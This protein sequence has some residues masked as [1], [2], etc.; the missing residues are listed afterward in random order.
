MSDRRGA[1]QAMPRSKKQ[2]APTSFGIR[3][4]EKWICYQADDSLKL[5]TPR[6]WSTIETPSAEK[7]TLLERDSRG[8]KQGGS[9]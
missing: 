4:L 9:A 8:H 2:I 3:Q 1:H 6:R 7:L 5:S